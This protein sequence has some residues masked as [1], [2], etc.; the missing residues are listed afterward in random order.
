MGQ[1]ETNELIRF[2]CGEN[3]S[4]RY[5]DTTLHSSLNVGCIQVLTD[6]TFDTLTD[7][8]RG[9]RVS[10]PLD[11]AETE[12]RQHCC[13]QPAGVMWR[14]IRN[15]LKR[16]IMLA[17]SVGPRN[18]PGASAGLKDGLLAWYNFEA[19]G[20]DSHTTARNL[21]VAGTPTYAAGKV[22]NAAFLDGS[23]ELLF[24]RSDEVLQTPGPRTWA[25][26][27]YFDDLLADYSIAAIVN[28]STANLLRLALDSANTR[29]KLYTPDGNITKG[30]IAATTWYF[31]VVTFNPATNTWTLDV[32]NSG[33]PASINDSIP[34]PSAA[35]D[36]FV[37]G[38][39]GNGDAV[40][41]NTLKG[42]LDS[43]GF[44]GRILTAAELTSLYNSGN[45][46]AYA[47]L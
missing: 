43:W 34:S 35:G 29:L 13:L 40:Y 16:L 9:H 30:T 23:A 7:V 41:I 36:V 10:G 47:D 24:W 22:N 5:A 39:D 42:G 18:N 28:D 45:G 38:V 27:V 4:T 11:G 15:L 8:P 12:R 31:V 17:L 14:R 3:G 1:R 2:A 46:K 6:A 26:W 33:T 20:N 44:W 37:M 19:N 32:N 25:G 21:T